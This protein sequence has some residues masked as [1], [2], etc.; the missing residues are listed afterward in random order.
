M[1]NDDTKFNE[2]YRRV[3][4]TASKLET[5]QS[6]LESV[7]D[8]FLT[9]IVKLYSKL[10]NDC[11]KL[12]FEC[13]F[14]LDHFRKAEELVWRRIYHDIYRFHRTKRLCVK[15]HDESLLESHFVAGI[16]FYSSLIV[17]LRYHYKIYDVQGVIVPLNLTL[18]PLDSFGLNERLNI[19]EDSLVSNDSDVSL[20]ESQSANHALARDWAKQAIYRSLVYMGDLARY[21][22]ETSHFDYRKLA[23]EFYKSAFKNQPDHGLPFNQLATLAGSMNHNLDAVCNYMR[24]CLRPKPFEG[25][26]GNMRKIFDLNNKFYKEIKDTGHICR[27]SDVLASK[28]PSASAE[29]M[30]KTII[31]TFIKL[32]SDLWAAITSD[33]DSEQAKIEIIEETQ[34][35]FKSLREALELEPIVPLAQPDDYEHEF[36]PISGGSSYE[37]KPRYIS[38]TIMYEFCT[39]SILLI[40]KCQKVRASSNQDDIANDYVTDLVNTLA[41]NLLHYST[42]KCQRMIMSKVQELRMNRSDFKEKIETVT[43]KNNLSS[44]SQKS[45]DVATTGFE[46]SSRRA[47]S[48]LRQRKA[49]ANYLDDQHHQRFKSMTHHNEDS[50]MSE[51]EETALSTIDALDISSEMSEDANYNDGDLIDLESSSSDDRSSSRNIDNNRTPSNLLNSNNLCRPILRPTR[52]QNYELEKSTS[53]AATNSLPVP[54]LLTGNVNFQEEDNLP[55]ATS[56][57][58]LESHKGS[59]VVERTSPP[60]LSDKGSA[61]QTKEASTLESSFAYIY[62]QSYLPTIK[63][64]CDW[65]LSNGAIISSNLESFRSFCSELDDLVTLLSDLKKL[66]ANN[67]VANASATSHIFEH[68]FDGS[69]WVQKYPLS[70]DY[71]LLYLGPLQSVHELNIDF[72]TSR[73]LNDSEAG[74]MT[75]QCVEAFL[76]ALNAFLEN[77]LS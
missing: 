39:V 23:F 43:F 1:M 2:D 11:L 14:K 26:E 48:R 77:K 10:C 75:V 55:P 56:E 42:S 29:S 40:A 24:C 41:L 28:E 4:A 30:V 69:T 31:V 50:D 58:P 15:K 36:L 70:C 37:E 9:P 25:A 19:V 44:G 46:A 49:A 7:I 61:S 22:L 38:P 54:D 71:P 51:L 18:E 35:F 21:L 3:L 68:T 6:N 62:T 13:E 63:I 12:L 53:L 8:F 16:G 60:S 65:I 64:F 5:I 57:S 45:L 34:L 32:T 66:A 72:K 52:S 20:K 17:R 73:D 59:D 74:F 27:I 47:L 76:Y 67:G 33:V